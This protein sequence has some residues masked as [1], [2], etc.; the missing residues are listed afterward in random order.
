M[1]RRSGAPSCGSVHR[2]R[3]SV[4]LEAALTLPLLLLVGATLLWAMGVAFTA[5]AMGDAVRT[6]ARLIAR[7]EDAG[8]VM[9]RL[10]DALP[11]AE[12]DLDSRGPDLMISAAQFV[13]APIPVFRGLGFTVTQSATAPL[14]SAG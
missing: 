10:Q 13:S 5:L 9:S 12:L 6:S 1:F 4:T 14:E 7:G 2:D 11:E 3:G 8:L